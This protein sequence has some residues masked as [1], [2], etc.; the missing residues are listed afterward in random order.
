[1]WKFQGQ[2]KK[3]K[4]SRE[5]LKKVCPQPSMFVFFSGIAQ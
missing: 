4:N 1:M 3:M 5:V 2:N